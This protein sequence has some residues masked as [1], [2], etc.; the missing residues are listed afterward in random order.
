MTESKSSIDAALLIAQSAIQAVA[1]DSTNTHHRYKYASADDILAASKAALTGAGLVL[2]R[3]G[4]RLAVHETSQ[5]DHVYVTYRLSHPASGG[6]RV[7]PDVPLPV[8]PGNGRPL[9]KAVLGALTSL[10]AYFRVGLLGIP[11]GDD[12]EVSSRDDT[13]GNPQALVREEP[14]P[15]LVA[16]PSLKMGVFKAFSGARTVDELLSAAQTQVPNSLASDA[17]VRAAYETRCD[18]LINE[19][20]RALMSAGSRDTLD[21]IWRSLGPSAR[22]KTK[23]KAAYATRGDELAGN[24]AASVLPP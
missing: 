2:E 9:D 1:K 6:E 15:A 23:I 18:Q 3:M 20:V 24:G 11:R 12:A 14:R 5:V 19:D 17:E 13:R 10:D 21:A 8:L 22:T 4:W 16:D 7:Y